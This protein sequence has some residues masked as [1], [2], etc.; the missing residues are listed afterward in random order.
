MGYGCGR[1]AGDFGESDKLIIEFAPLLRTL[2][3]E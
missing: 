3:F 2:F 1:R